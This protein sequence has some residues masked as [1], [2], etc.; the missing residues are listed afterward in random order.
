MLILRFAK[1]VNLALRHARVCG[2]NPS[3]PDNFERKR[4]ERLEHFN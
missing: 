3:L 1:E 2:N 4:F